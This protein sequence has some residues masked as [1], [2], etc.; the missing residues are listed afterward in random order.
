MGPDRLG[1]GSTF[2][3]GTGRLGAGSTWAGST[4]DGSTWGRVDPKTK[5]QVVAVYGPRQS[6][7]ITPSFKF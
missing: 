4:W 3:M 1:A 2:K 5:V 7:I 6:L